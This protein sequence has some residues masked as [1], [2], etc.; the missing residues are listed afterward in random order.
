M[1]ALTLRTP[2][3]TL[4]TPLPS[5]SLNPSPEGEAQTGASV[6]SES[7]VSLNVRLAW[8]E[9]GVWSSSEVG[10]GGGERGRSD[11]VSEEMKVVYARSGCLDRLE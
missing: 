6:T 5:W 2:R 4:A 9:P 3:L 7:D 10:R 8:R 1:S 11:G